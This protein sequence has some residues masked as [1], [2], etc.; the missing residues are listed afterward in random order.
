[1][2]SYCFF[3]TTGLKRGISSRRCPHP[4]RYPGDDLIKSSLADPRPTSTLRCQFD[5]PSPRRPH[6]GSISRPTIVPSPRRLVTAG[7]V[8][9]AREN[10]PA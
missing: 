10:I 9:N 3:A 2:R 4:P 1:M 6:I 5:R 7:R 8:E